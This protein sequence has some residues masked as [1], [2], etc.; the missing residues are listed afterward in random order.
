MKKGFSYLIIFLFFASI[1]QAQTQRIVL[2]EE[3]TNASCSPCATYNPIL[4]KFYASHFGGVISV[5][6]HAWWPGS[7]DPMYVSASTDC[8]RRINYYGINGVPTYVMDGV[9]KGVPADYDAMVRQLEQR[10]AQPAPLKILVHSKIVDDSVLAKVRLIPLKEV[11]AGNL[12]LRVAVTQRMVSYQSPPGSNGEKDFPEVL[13]KMLPNATGTSIPALTIGDTLDFEFSTVAKSDW[14]IGDLAVVAWL[15]SDDSKEVLQSN[16]DF[17]TFFVQLADSSFKFAKANALTRFSFHLFNRND[18]TIHVQL[19]FKNVQAT[20]NWDYFFETENNADWQQPIAIAA[21]DSFH[22]KAVIQSAD[23]GSF[24]GQVFVEN[25]DDPGFYGEGYGYG[26][27]HDVTIVVPENTDLLLVDDDGGKNYEENFRQILNKKKIKYIVLGESN[28]LQLS[29]QFDLN[30]YKLIIWNVSWAFPA[31]TA[32][33]IEL[34]TTYLDGG[35]SLAIFGQ[36]IGWDIFDSQ[37]NSHFQKAIDFIHNY[38]DVQ[39][40]SDNSKGISF[41]GVENDPIGDGLSFDLARTYGF[42]N[43]FPEELKSYTGNSKPVFKYNN[44]KIGALRYDNGHFKTVYFG[45]GFEQIGDA[46]LRDSVLMRILNWSAGITSVEEKSPELPTTHLLLNNYPNPFNNSTKIVFEVTKQSQVGL[47][48]FDSR[49]RKVKQWSDKFL[50]GKHS[51]IWNGENQ[52]GKQLASGIYF[53]RLKS[54]DQ[55]RIRKM[56]LLR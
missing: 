29:K 13:R 47:T 14:E 16:I 21:G 25:L 39:Y 55:M 36:D 38:F 49:G 1:L 24:S 44:G 30:A 7:S 9:P 26:V 4:Q 51:L 48:I 6:Y 40:V 27:G 20:N 22:F 33:D 56:I 43:F 15:Q 23:F 8:R 11:T 37:G 19:K 10:L 12:Y 32:E 35:G 28:T 52:N 31:F 18:T 42:A 17:P 46:A 41:V 3:A 53:L 5:R 2:L 34:L 54:K 50:A 45:V